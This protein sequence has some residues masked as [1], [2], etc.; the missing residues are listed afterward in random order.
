M[1][2][3]IQSIIDNISLDAERRKSER[4]AQIA[5]AVD[6][7]IEKE[8]AVFLEELEKRREQLIK[9]NE[10]ELARRQERIKSRF[11]RE[12]LVYQNELTDSIFDMAVNKLR[13]IS[14]EVFQEMVLGSLNGLSGAFTLK[15]GSLSAD[16]LEAAT[17]EKAA[18]MNEALNVSVSEETVP[19]KSGF[20]LTDDRVEYNCLFEDLIEDKKSELTADILHEVFG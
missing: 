20:I 7:E 11:H 19:N 9:N 1:K 10:L 2:A 14:K 5:D 6:G 17:I 8:N 12:V 18:Q 16:W 15:L 13:G 4:Y 3:G